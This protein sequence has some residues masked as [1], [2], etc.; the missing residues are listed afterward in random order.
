MIDTWFGIVAWF[1]GEFD[2]AARQLEQTTAGFAATGH[3]TEGPPRLEERFNLTVVWPTA[4]LVLAHLVRGELH[5]CRSRSGERG[6][7]D[8]RVQ[9]PRRAIQPRLR[10]LRGDLAAPRSG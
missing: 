7:F 5:R 8:T 1:G 10:A 4:N 9:V 2:A 6:T 3:R